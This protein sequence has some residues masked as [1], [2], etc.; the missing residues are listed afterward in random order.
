MFDDNGYLRLGK[1]NTVKTISKQQSSSSAL[2]E[3]MNLEAQVKENINKIKVL[4][5]TIDG[6]KL[7]IGLKEF[8]TNLGDFI[9]TDES[10]FDDT[11][12]MTDMCNYKRKKTNSVL[13]GDY[14]N[15]YD[16]I[17]KLITEISNG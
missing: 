10:I 5:S 9:F 15:V 16:G 7:V 13:V 14:T 11:K 1:R 3:V 2:G 8:S 17:K 12:K 4:R 6:D